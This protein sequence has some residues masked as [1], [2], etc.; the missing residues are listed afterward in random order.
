MN[1]K[2]IDARVTHIYLNIQ[3][4][5]LGTSNVFNFVIDCGRV[6][7]NNDESIDKGEKSLVGTL[8]WNVGIYELNKR[9]SNYD[10][11]CG[12]SIIAPNVIISGKLLVQCI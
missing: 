1:Y 11:I 3:L 9:N 7:V 8:P 4:L 2:L 6:Y 5:I 12:G 10:L